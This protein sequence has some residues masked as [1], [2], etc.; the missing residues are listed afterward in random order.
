MRAYPQPFTNIDLK[1][2]IIYDLHTLMSKAYMSSSQY[3]IKPFYN[4]HYGA[5]NKLGNYN[6]KFIN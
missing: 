2:K 4:Y 6:Y 5:H 3:G 1:R